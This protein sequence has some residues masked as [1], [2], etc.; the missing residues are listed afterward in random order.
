MASDFTI[1]VLMMVS[2]NAITTVEASPSDNVLKIKSKVEESS[3]IPVIHQRLLHESAELLDTTLLEE[4]SVPASPE[5]YLI[6]RGDVGF[7]SDAGVTSYDG[8]NVAEAAQVGALGDVMRLVEAG[9]DIN[10]KFDGYTALH[11]MAAVPA[12]KGGAY[13]TMRPEAAVVMMRWLC[14]H[15]ADVN[16]GDGGGKTPL[17]VFGK[18]GGHMDQLQ[19]LIDKRADVNQAMNYGEGWTPLWY[20]RN[21]K[22]PIWREVEAA[23]LDLGAKQEP[24]DLD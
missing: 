10:A 5:V 9:A 20:C 17:H 4:T 14:E 22:R 21:Y 2:G 15:G 24:G 8:E 12:A 19:V 11:H 1:S 23:L 16:S 13:D 3:G 6:N 7:L 18:Y